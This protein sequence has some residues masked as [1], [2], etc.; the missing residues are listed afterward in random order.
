VE[1]MGEH[2]K[3]VLK[4]LP[5]VAGTY[6]LKE[7]KDL[8]VLLLPGDES[9]LIKGVSPSVLVRRLCLF[10]TF[11]VDKFDE[12]T[13]VLWQFAEGVIGHEDIWMFAYD[14]HDKA[15]Q[16]EMYREIKNKYLEKILE[17][18]KPVLIIVSTESGK[19]VYREVII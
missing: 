14:Q 9:L 13:A 5:T 6:E 7:E 3:I 2:T 17:D 12:N 16:K 19:L 11:Q 1:L 8:I 10:K 18:K 15:V 4:K